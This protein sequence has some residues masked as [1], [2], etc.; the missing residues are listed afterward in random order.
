M[1]EKMF[2]DFCLDVAMDPHI[3]RCT[4]APA[5]FNNLFASADPRHLIYKKQQPFDWM[6]ANV[7]PIFKMGRKEDPGKLVGS[8]PHSSPGKV[9][10]DAACKR[11]EALWE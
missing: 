7:T 9:T 11:K 8:Q 4:E 1:V 2:G 5:G 6:K 10:K 3:S